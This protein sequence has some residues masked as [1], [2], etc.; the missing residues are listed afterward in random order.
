MVKT[1]P[2]GARLSNQV[3]PVFWIKG[4]KA[5]DVTRLVASPAR[6]FSIRVGQR[7]QGRCNR[8]IWRDDQGENLEGE[9]KEI[10][11]WEKEG[12]TLTQQPTSGG[13][14]FPESTEA[15]RQPLNKGEG[16][17]HF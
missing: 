5:L 4:A 3:N 13:R 15:W 9:R 6:S 8:W 11:E 7:I 12:G 17:D 10:Q 1:G 2:G 14:I 16:G